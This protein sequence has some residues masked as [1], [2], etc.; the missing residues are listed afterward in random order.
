MNS[1]RPSRAEV[2]IGPAGQ[3]L[4]IDDI[5]KAEVAANVRHGLISLEEACFHYKMSVDE[6][7]AWVR[8]LE[9]HGVPEWRTTQLQNYRVSGYMH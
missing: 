2:V 7:L 5:R 1:E 8:V 3:P 4:T 9:V 6:V